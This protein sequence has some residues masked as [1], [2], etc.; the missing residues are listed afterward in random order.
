MVESG[1]H[2]SLPVV[3]LLGTVAY[4]GG[5]ALPRAWSHLN[6]DFPNYYLTA[7]LLHE[8]TAP[9]AYTNGSGYSARRIAWVFASDQPLV[10]FLP[11][12]PFSALLVWPLTSLPPLAAKRVWIILNLILLGLA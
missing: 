2:S 8:A 5:R 9:A 11:D 12:T 10:G 7:R 4:I 1:G 3:C 6:T